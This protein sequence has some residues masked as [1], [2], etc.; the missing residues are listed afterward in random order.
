MFPG[1]SVSKLAF[2][3]LKLDDAVKLDYGMSVP[4][5]AEVLSSG[6]RFFAFGSGRSYTQVFAPLVERRHDLVMSNPWVNRLSVR[7]TLPEGHTIG[8]LPPAVDD[9]TP[10][11]RLT[12]ACRAEG[13][14]EVVCDSEVTLKVARVKASDYPAF[15]AFLGRVDQ[16]FA[17]KLH[18]MKASLSLDRERVGVRVDSP[19][20]N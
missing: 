9:D 8:N 17:R 13:S 1:L 10:F 12:L 11:G 4:R 19:S 18:V 15:R 7:Y 2:A 6:L 20:A 14:T 16:A 5:Y 3:E